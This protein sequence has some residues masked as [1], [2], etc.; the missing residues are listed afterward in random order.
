MAPG[1]HVSGGV[2]QAAIASPPGSGTGAQIACFTAAVFAADGGSNFFPAGQ[3][4]YT[5]SSGTSHSTPAI[6]GVA[7]LIRQHFIN[8]ALTPPSPA[9]TKALMMNSARYMT[10]VGAN[11]TLPSNNQGMGEIN[12]NSYFDIFATAHSFHD[13]VPADTFTASGQQRIIT[14]TVSDIRSRFA[15]RWPGPTRPGRPRATPSSTTSTSKSRSAA[16]PTRAMSSAARSPPP[17][18]S[19]TLATTSRASSFRP[20]S[21]ARS[22]SRSRP[23][24]SPATACPATRNPLDQDFALVAYNVTEAPLPVISGGATRITAESCSPAN[25]AIDPGETVTVNFD[26]VERRH[27]QHHQPGRDACRRPAVSLRPAVRRTM[28]S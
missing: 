26:L 12:L 2:A 14:G 3:Q 24:T 16:I 23:P 25:N 10:G 28:A 15:S 21:A 1:T 18:A 7:A 9:M 27:G 8:Q 5:A 17:A 20:E 13:Q 22:S 19:R 6:A 11:D 4:W